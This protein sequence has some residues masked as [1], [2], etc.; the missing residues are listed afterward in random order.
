MRRWPAVARGT[1]SARA[2]AKARRTTRDASASHAIRSLQAGRMPWTVRSHPYS[3]WITPTDDEPARVAAVNST[4]RRSSSTGNPSIVVAVTR[5]TVRLLSRRR[6]D[7]GGARATATRAGS[8]A[9]AGEP[10][11]WA[12]PRTGIGPDMDGHS[13]HGRANG[14][15]SDHKPCWVANRPASRTWHPRA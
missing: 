8:D 5:S 3:R 2:T 6:Q 1:P 9:C 7:N 13:E 14:T 10:G 11:R 12:T 4:H 15:V